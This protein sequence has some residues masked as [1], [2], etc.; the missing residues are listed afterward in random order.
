MSTPHN[1]ISKL[2]LEEIEAFVE[3]ARAG[4]FSAA[5]ER[6]NIAHS[7]LS[8][9]VAKLEDRLGTKLFVR[10]ANGVTLTETGSERFLRFRDA[11]QIIE[12]SFGGLEPAVQTQV[13]RMSMLDSFAIF[14]LFP[15]HATFSRLLPGIELQY[16]VSS[17]LADFNDGISLAVR[18]GSGN[19]PGMESANILSLDF[20]PMAC[21]AIAERLG[22]NAAPEQLL[23]YPLVHLG[24]E[25]AWTHWLE[26]NGVSYRMRPQD[27]IFGELPTSLAAVQNGL[28][29]GISR[30]PF[31][32]IV[33]TG[34]NLQHVNGRSVGAPLGYHL[35]RKANRELSPA[36]RQF[37]D[38]LL[39]EAG[40]SRP[41]IQQFLAEA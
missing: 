12:V 30:Q 13:V 10:K 1:T 14:W 4:S 16:E 9:K 24:T 40:L 11:L 31:R 19:W 29:L 35:V 38:A 18:F 34:G 3:V 21:K 39:K 20:R 27:R 17:R 41:S 33:D 28:G 26:A 37:A 5:A 6:L 7:S 22:A 25:A 32:H 8:R 15:R 2:P 36:A 23:A